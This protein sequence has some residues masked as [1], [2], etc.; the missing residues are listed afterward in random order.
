MS[1]CKLEV[2]RKNPG[3]KSA[4]KEPRI[5]EFAEKDAVGSQRAMDRATEH[6]DGKPP[7]LIK[8]GVSKLQSKAEDAKMIDEPKTTDAKK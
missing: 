2:G 6:G 3:W 5:F 4:A 8:A 1:G 7:K